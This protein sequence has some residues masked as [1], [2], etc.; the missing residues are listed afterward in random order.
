MVLPFTK[1]YQVLAVLIGFLFWEVKVSAQCN[2]P[3]QLPTNYCETAPLNCLLNACYQTIQDNFPDCCS[4]WCNGGFL[5]HNPQFFEMIAA[6]TTIEIHIDVLSCDDG[7][8]LQ[9]AIIGACPWS[10]T[11]NYPDILACDGQTNVGY[12]MVLMIDSAVIGNSYWLM[13]DGFSSALC[14]YLISY[15]SGI[16]IPPLEGVLDPDESMAIPDVVCPGYGEIAV[17]AGPPIGLAHGYMW[18]TEWNNDT[19]FSTLPEITINIPENMPPG[20]WEI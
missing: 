6:S 20:V 8:S 9:G 17:V 12:T 4:G 2:P 11:I 1:S 3:E 16:L 10:Q 15:V 19:I 7:T 13:I 5:I 18:I 14:N